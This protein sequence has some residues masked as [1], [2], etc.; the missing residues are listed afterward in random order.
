MV[1]YMYMNKEQSLLILV[2]AVKFAQSK[3]IYSL[4]DSRKI[5]NALDVIFA[6]APVEQAPVV[7][8][9]EELPVTE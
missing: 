4:E 6:P 7:E 5:A 9:P 8:K 2:E 3:G 1:E